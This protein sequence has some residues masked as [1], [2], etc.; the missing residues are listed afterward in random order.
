MSE[1][2]APDSLLG[3]FS[4]TMTW[5]TSL[6]RMTGITEFLSGYQG[7]VNPD[8][9]N[10]SL[11]FNGV[12]YEGTAGEVKIFRVFFEPIGDIGEVVK[13]DVD[14]SVMAAA[15]TFRDLT[16]DIIEFSCIGRIGEGDLLG[17]VNGDGL[18]NST[19]ALIILSF[20]AG[21]PIPADL[22]ARINA[23]IGDVNM[24]GFTTSTDAL[25]VL[26]FEAGF[27]V[28]YPVGE[29]FCPGQMHFENNE[30]IM[31]IMV[32]VTATLERLPGTDHEVFLPVTVDMTDIGRRL[33]SYTVTISWDPQHLEWIGYSGGED[34][35]LN[36]PVINIL[37]TEEGIMKIAW[38][39]P[40]G[41]EGVANLFN[42]RFKETGNMEDSQLDLQFSDMASTMTFTP[43]L[44]TVMFQT[45]TSE[46]ESRFLSMTVYPNPFEESTTIS[47]RI[48]KK[49]QG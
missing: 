22:L 42:L 36:N 21:L 4:A 10:G 46:K 25:I 27:P 31:E 15:Y 14:F 32:P 12:K 30:E 43:L 8:T 23:K 11:F 24:D 6:L 9:L 40:Q 2:P 34:E 3:S 48:L 19:D 41:G 17:D 39:N 47:Y 44:P 45:A 16:A 33:G 13:V 49:K 1:I 5:D 29:Q 28:D 18:V 26:T 37:N 35:E 38:A 7:V 20:D